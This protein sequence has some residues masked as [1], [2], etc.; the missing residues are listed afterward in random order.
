MGGDF[1]TYIELHNGQ[2]GIVVGDVSGK[3][4]PAAMAGALAVGLIEAYASTHL[5][6]ESLLAQLNKDLHA[7]FIS[8]YINVACCY[9]ILDTTACRL[10]LGNAGCVYPYLRRGAELS[11]IE[12]SGFPLGMWPDFHYTS[13]SL[14]LNRGD[15]LM[16][17]SDG[18][19]EAKNEQGDLFGFDRL[20]TEL[21]SLP[22]GI[23][24]QS[25]VDQLV[26]SVMTFTGQ[27]DLHDDLTILV[28]RVS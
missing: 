25:A 17:S 11:E 7:R 23:D 10:T 3:G 19:V 21:Q 2:R 14:L 22:A 28:V 9:A 27:A 18:L 12:V 15:L 16:F 1:Y 24:A 13:R 6:P 20:Q 8:N 4:A 5:K 26:S